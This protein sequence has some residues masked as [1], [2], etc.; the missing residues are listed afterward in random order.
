MGAKFP[1]A[2]DIFE[3]VANT[4]WQTAA[5]VITADGVNLIDLRDVTFW[6]GAG[7]AGIGAGWALF[8]T[9][10]AT[11]LAKRNGKASSASLDPA[12]QL[13]PVSHPVH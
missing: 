7:I 9:L 1:I 5:A 10:V 2:R 4:A 13:E 11:Q 8:K 3:R 6:Q 12:V